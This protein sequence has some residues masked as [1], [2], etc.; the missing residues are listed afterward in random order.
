[1]GICDSK[2]VGHNCAFILL[3]THCSQPFSLLLGCF[4]LVFVDL[5]LLLFELGL[6]MTD[7]AKI[8]LILHL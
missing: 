2:C 6:E 3:L 8:L 7:F 1:M 5:L 4:L